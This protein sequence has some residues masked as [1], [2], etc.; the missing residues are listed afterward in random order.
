[1]LTPDERTALTMVFRKLLAV[2]GNLAAQTQRGNDTAEG[3]QE[4]NLRTASWVRV[5]SKKSSWERALKSGL[6]DWQKLQH[7]AEIGLAVPCRARRTALDEG[8]R[9]PDRLQDSIGGAGDIQD[10]RDRQGLARNRV[11]MRAT[12]QAGNGQSGGGKGQEAAAV[13][14]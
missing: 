7:R 14:V 10:V 11:G 13:H 5:N 1:M 6:K 4:S 3:E 8:R 2:F 9:A 12:D